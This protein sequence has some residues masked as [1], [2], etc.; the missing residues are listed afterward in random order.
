MIPSLWFMNDHKE[1]QNHHDDFFNH[2]DVSIIS[3]VMIHHDEFTTT[4]FQF[5]NDAS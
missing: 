1:Y 2:H 3:S 5:N 4:I